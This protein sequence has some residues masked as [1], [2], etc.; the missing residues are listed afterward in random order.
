MVE[1]NELYDKKLN[2]NYG[3]VQKKEILVAEGNL[4]LAKEFTSNTVNF[5]KS[6]KKEL[7]EHTASDK[8]IKKKNTTSIKELNTKHNVHLKDIGSREKDFQKDYENDLQSSLD[9]FEADNKKLNDLVVVLNKDNEKTIKDTLVQYEKD[10]ENSEL[11]KVKIVELAEKEMKILFAALKD[12]QDKYESLVV[13]LNEKRD[14]K[15]EKLNTT[16]TK[17]KN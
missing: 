10:I 8:E 12:T 9:K 17:K 2:K 15:T 16:S 3:T 1:K 14:E 6:L 7:N 4:K 13:N 11:E 5:S